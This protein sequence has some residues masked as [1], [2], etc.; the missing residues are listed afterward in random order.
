MIPKPPTYQPRLRRRPDATSFSEDVLAW[1]TRCHLRHGGTCVKTPS[2]GDANSVLVN[3]QHRQPLRPRRRAADAV[4]LGRPAAPTTRR[5]P[6]RP[7]LPRYFVD[8]G[9]TTYTHVA[10]QHP[11]YGT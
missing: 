2:E 6:D 4:T 7:G 10:D 11:T 8:D 5:K 9:T 3:H 1:T